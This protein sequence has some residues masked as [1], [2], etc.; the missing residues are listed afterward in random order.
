MLMNAISTCERMAEICFIY[1][2]MGSRGKYLVIL[3]I[4]Y[5]MLTV[6]LFLTP[7]LYLDILQL[8]KTPLSEFHFVWK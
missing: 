3:F 6:K 7:T 8:L 2:L 1:G 5:I 4:F